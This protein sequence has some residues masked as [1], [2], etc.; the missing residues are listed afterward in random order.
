MKTIATSYS[1]IKGKKSDYYIGKDIENN[2]GDIIGV[3]T[4]ASVNKKF[5]RVYFDI[6]L[7]D[8]YED[9]SYYIQITQNKKG[10]KFHL[11]LVDLPKIKT[12]KRRN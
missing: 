10:G 9:T 8:G 3:V 11:V 12:R 1:I 7:D 2:N 5:K 6:F 4:D